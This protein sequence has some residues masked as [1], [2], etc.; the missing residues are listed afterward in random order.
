LFVP[1]TQNTNVVL[2]EGESTIGDVAFGFGLFWTVALRYDEVA[3]RRVQN[4][5]AGGYG[6]PWS[7][8]FENAEFER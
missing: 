5:P 1:D 6:D 4:V 8:I 2:L 7:I 3:L